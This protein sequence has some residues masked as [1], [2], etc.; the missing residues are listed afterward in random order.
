MSTSKAIKLNFK[1][2]LESFLKASELNYKY[3][4]FETNRKLIGWFLIALTQF[5]VVAALKQGAYELLLFS[6]ITLLYWYYAKWEIK[7]FIIKKSFK[8]A[9]EKEF[10]LELKKENININE[11]N[12]DTKFIR[13]IKELKDGF[14]IYL[15][16][17]NIYIPKYAF[18]GSSVSDFKKIYKDYI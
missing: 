5:G 10:N 6:T 8:D 18:K 11:T 9:D 13:Y 16:K 17:K 7:K 15:N 4:L 12:I 14:V 2:D 3:E 1:W